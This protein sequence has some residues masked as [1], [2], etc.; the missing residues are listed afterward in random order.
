[1]LILILKTIHRSWKGEN[2]I[3][4]EYDESVVLTVLFTI[5]SSLGKK[6]IRIVFWFHETRPI[7][8]FNCIH[9]I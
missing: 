5:K 3:N 8:I 7:N 4:R 1:M 6:K 2:S 9:D